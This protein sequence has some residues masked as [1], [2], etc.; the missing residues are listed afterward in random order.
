MSVQKSLIPVPYILVPKKEM[1]ILLIIVSFSKMKKKINLVSRIAKKRR[2]G[3][4]G[5]ESFTFKCGQFYN[6][7]FGH[8]LVV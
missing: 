5:V 3:G 7:V 2:R 6:T 8:T 4:G 1:L